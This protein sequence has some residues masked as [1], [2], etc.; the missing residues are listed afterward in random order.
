MK[1]GGPTI[2]I[3]KV[4][5]FGLEYAEVACNVN[6]GILHCKSESREGII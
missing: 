2:V 5:H 6:A 3:T 4:Y 1:D